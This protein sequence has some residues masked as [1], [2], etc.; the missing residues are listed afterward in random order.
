MFEFVRL[1][2][3][4]NENENLHGVLRKF[5]PFELNHFIW[6]LALTRFVDDDEKMFMEDLLDISYILKNGA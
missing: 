5:S 1:W 3:S 6:E 2:I 4:E